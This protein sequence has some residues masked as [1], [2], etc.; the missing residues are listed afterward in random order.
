MMVRFS[1]VVLEVKNVPA[2]SG[3]VRDVGSISVSGRPSAGEHGNPLKY[4][5]LEI[6]MDRGAM[7]HRFAQNWTQLKEHNMHACM[8]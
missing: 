4:S 7:V 1:Q 3:N 2:I 5:C 6:P 8:L